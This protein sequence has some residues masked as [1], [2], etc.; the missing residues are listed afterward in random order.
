MTDDERYRR[1]FEAVLDSPDSFIGILDPDGTLRRA[2]DTALSFVEAGPDGVEGDPFWEGPWWNH[3]EELQE[4]LRGWIA[5]A[6][7]GEYVRYEAVHEGPDGS[8]V[9]VDGVL[10]PVTD[11]DGAV[12]AIIAEGREVTERREQARRLEQLTRIE[13]TLRRVHR[14]L[15]AATDREGLERA[16]CE[17]LTTTDVYDGAWLG[18]YDPAS[19]RI[20]PVASS[21]VSVTR[22]ADIDVRVDDS[23]RGQGPAGEAVRTGSV[24]AVQD[25]ATAPSLAPWREQLLARDVASLACLP[26]SDG[27][28]TYGVVSVYADRPDVFT[29]EEQA[30]LAELGDSVGDALAGLAARAAVERQN[31]RLER[32]ASILSHDLRNPLNVAQGR[33]ALALDDPEEA[34]EHL[35]DVV[36]ALDRMAALVDDTLALVR[37]D[38]RVEAPEPVALGEFARTSWQ[39]V[40]SGT[41]TLEVADDATVRADPDRLR[42]LLENLMRNSVEHG[43]TSG[44]NAERSRDAVTVTVG[45]LDGAT[46][47]YVADDGPGVP[48]DRREQVFERGVT[49]AADGTGFGLAIVEDVADAHGWSV[50]LTASSD[51]GARFEVTGVDVLD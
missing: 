6:A 4:R 10:R 35:S 19:E 46:G 12:V 21:G 27:E 24:V 16:V 50:A 3:S 9:E 11:D 33:A 30:A 47:F 1:M 28:T 29:E 5:R 22:L 25:V 51:G 15:V 43:S 13:E 31:E 34:P 7:D 41:A 2:N 49:T 14:E 20:E 18:R 42:R 45:G 23:E 36:A 44:Q 32:F 17:A 26:V 38:G 40:D 8:A 48:P 39:T 37:D